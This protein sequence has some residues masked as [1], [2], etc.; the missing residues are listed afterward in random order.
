L[1]DK[2]KQAFSAELRADKINPVYPKDPAL[3]R[4]FGAFSNSSAGVSVNER[5][6][7]NVAAL[8]SIV[9]MIAEDIAQAPIRL[10]NKKTF[11]EVNTR[12]SDLL[13][14]DPNNYQ[15]SFEYRETMLLTYLLHGRAIAIQKRNRR[16]E[17][18][19]LEPVEYDQTIV[20]KEKNKLYYKLNSEIYLPDEVVDVRGPSLDGGVTCLTPIQQSKDAI[21]NARAADVYSGRFFKQG[22]SPSGI[23]ATDA[24]LSDKAY[25]RLKEWI[26]QQ[27][28][29][30]KSHTPSI[31][32]EGLKYQQ[33][34]V[35]PIDMQL[36]ESR[37]YSRAEI[38]A[39]YR[40][41][42]YKLGEQTSG[43]TNT[44]QQAIDYLQEAIVPR[45]ARFEQAHNKALLTLEQRRQLTVDL[46]LDALLRGDYAAKAAW[47]GKQW[48]IGAL[49]V[50]EIRNKEGRKK[51]DN[52]DRRFSPAN[53][54]PTD[55][56]DDVLLKNPGMSQQTN[57]DEPTD[58]GNTGISDTI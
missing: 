50:N 55:L 25:E 11:D 37:K 26:A 6:A 3:A 32:E 19:A 10:L 39:L 23:V 29:A 44:E 47:Y 33:L 45:V 52:G 58:K 18:I 54:V 4:M 46:D 36:L 9:T 40:V 35:N 49:T 1:F 42:A 16:G 34:S 48:S 22:F 28:G 30:D 14:F 56:I 20:F 51:V 7:L 31:L 24:Q 8:F 27:S 21:G 53:M 5:T 41:P 12:E 57:E 38:A 2:I 17:L 13:Q 43:I 15:S